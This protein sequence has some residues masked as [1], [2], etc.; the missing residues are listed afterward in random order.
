MFD[1]SNCRYPDS[2]DLFRCQQEIDEENQ[3]PMK[4][5]RGQGT[6][7]SYEENIDLRAAI[8]TTSRRK[9]D[10]VIPYIAK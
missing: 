5:F 8:K 4:K 6:T 10:V 3:N 1:P 7:S 9:F 2:V